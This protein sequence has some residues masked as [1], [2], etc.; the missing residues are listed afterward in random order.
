MHSSSPLKG[1][2]VTKRRSL[3][4]LLCCQKVIPRRCP[5]TVLRFG[6]NIAGGPRRQFGV[7]RVIPKRTKTARPQKNKG[8]MLKIYDPKLFSKPMPRLPLT[9]GETA[10]D[11][12]CLD[13]D[14]PMCLFASFVRADVMLLISAIYRSISHG[15][16]QSFVLL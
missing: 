12:R 13:G 9:S 11:D 3:N 16:A 4:R 7:R 2:S 6:R 8:K 1:F 5:V 14:H 15:R 10:D